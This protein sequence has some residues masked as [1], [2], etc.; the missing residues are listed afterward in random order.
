MLDSSNHAKYIFFATGAAGVRAWETMRL[1]TQAAVRAPAFRGTCGITRTNSD[2]S[3]FKESSMRLTIPGL[4]LVAFV[5][6]ACSTA[7]DQGGDTGS[8]GQSVQG[9]TTEQAATPAGPQP[10]SQMDLEVN[11]GDRVLDRKSTL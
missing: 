11:V 9:Q 3:A 10:G 1:E 7:S 8:A 4:I 5:L 6:G 2:D